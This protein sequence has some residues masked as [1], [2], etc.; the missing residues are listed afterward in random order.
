MVHPKAGH[1]ILAYITRTS[2]SVYMVINSMSGYELCNPTNAVGPT[3]K[4]HITGFH[5]EQ[6]YT[7]QPF[8]VT[9]GEIDKDRIGPPK[10]LKLS[11]LRPDCPRYTA[12][13]KVSNCGFKSS[14]PQQLTT[15][16]CSGPS[17]LNFLKWQK[18]TPGFS[19]GTKY[20]RS[21]YL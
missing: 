19:Q 7:L 10:K 13:D 15:E 14:L 9:N 18:L 20:R 17:T 2:P 1:T 12:G 11:D 8:G 5:L 6:V 4:N 21:T 3:L 16:E